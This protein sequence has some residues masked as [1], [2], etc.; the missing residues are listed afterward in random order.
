[1][2]SNA[3]LQFESSYDYVSDG[4]RDAAVVYNYEDSSGSD[5][6]ADEVQNDFKINS[7]YENRVNYSDTPSGRHLTEQ[8][9]TCY[10]RQ[11]VPKASI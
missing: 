8:D 2:Q 11:H 4:V 10:T 5:I 3:L 9:Q 1:M 7:V 6:G